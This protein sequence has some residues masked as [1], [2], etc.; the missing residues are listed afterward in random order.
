MAKTKTKT[1]PQKA[2]EITHRRHR[3]AELYLRGMYQY[4][5][6]QELDTSEATVNADLKA[7]QKA[8]LSSSVRN[9]DEARAQEVA[10]IDQAEREY[11]RAWVRSQE[12]APDEPQF[13]PVGSPGSE[14]GQPRLWVKPGDPR[15]LQGVER[16]VE[17]RCKLLGLDAPQKFDVTGSGGVTVIAGVD[18]EAALGRRLVAPVAS[19]RGDDATGGTGTAGELVLN[20]DDL[21]E[22]PASDGSGEHAG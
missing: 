9:F 1:T 22:V 2:A 14:A 17:R 19:I 3:V 15:F 16:C 12:P 21:N 11:W 4:Q 10:K 5:I 13:Y 6:A 18:G 7:V 20:G 8:W